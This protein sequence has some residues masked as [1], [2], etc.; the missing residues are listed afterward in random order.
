MLDRT[1]CARPQ[2]WHVQGCMLW[3]ELA[4]YGRRSRFQ[5]GYP[6]Y[7]LTLLAPFVLSAAVS[8]ALTGLVGWH[9]YI[10]CQGQVKSSR[11]GRLM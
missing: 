6:V 5:M 7:P 1:A 10:I 3:V 8:A 2:T 9:A 4:S 11:V